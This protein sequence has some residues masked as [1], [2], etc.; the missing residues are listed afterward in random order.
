[1]KTA[2]L[3]AFVCVA[4]LMQP[5][6]VFGLALSEVEVFSYLNQPLDARVRLPA[7]SAVELASLDV[8]VSPVG[9]TT[10]LEIRP[11]VRQDAEGAYIQLT[12][13]DPV[14]EPA[15]RL[16]LEARWAGGTMQREYALLVNPR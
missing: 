5:W 1:M 7:A 8:T 11:E 2:L 6:A 13:R 4:F 16:R 9:A 15:L 14:R 10:Y 3:R 12:S